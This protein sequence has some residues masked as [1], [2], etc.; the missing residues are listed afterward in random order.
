MDDW[1]RYCVERQKLSPL[2]LLNNRL[3]SLYQVAEEVGTNMIPDMLKMGN[4]TFGTYQ[5]AKFYADLDE[6]EYA[7]LRLPDHDNHAMTNIQVENH[8]FVH[9]S[10]II[11]CIINNQ[12]MIHLLQLPIKMWPYDTEKTHYKLSQL[13]LILS[14]KPMIMYRMICID[15]KIFDIFINNFMMHVIN[16]CIKY[17]KKHNKQIMT[18]SEMCEDGVSRSMEDVYKA[19]FAVNI[20]GLIRNCIDDKRRDKLSRIHLQC[21]KKYARILGKDIDSVYES[22][23]ESRS[24]KTKKQIKCGNYLC[25]KR[26][27]RKTFKICKGCFVTFYCSHKCQKYDWNIFGHRRLC[28]MMQQMRLNNALNEMR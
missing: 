7:C 20:F 15:Y 17:N 5:F 10:W 18:S 24:F 16:Y 21:M 25:G 2:F 13:G 28:D 4:L 12:T 3:S 6:N 23:S 19:C 1:K 9:I 22:L 8:P 11:N 27:K 26:N 14:N